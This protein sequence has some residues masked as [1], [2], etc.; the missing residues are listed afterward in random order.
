MS[1]K[2]FDMQFMRYM[3]LFARI[4]GIAP[5][6][7]F[8]YNN[9]LVFIIPGFAIERAIGRD[10]SNLKKLSAIFG[11]RIRVVAEPN[12][13]KDLQKFVKILVSPVEFEK[14]EIVETLSENNNNTLKEAVVTTSNREQ[15]AM[16]IGRGRAREDELKNILEQ[17][18]GAKNLRIN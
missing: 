11:K 8:A 16:L 6:H 17:Y 10:N 1:I 9:M 4:T 7:C 14:I 2:K 3:N 5:K 18:F 13:L 12:G 15:K